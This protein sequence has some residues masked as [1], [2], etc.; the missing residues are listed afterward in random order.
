MVVAGDWWQDFFERDYDWLFA[1]AISPEETERAV[2]DLVALVGIEPGWR[3]LD[4]PGG[5]G[6]HAVPL[7]L[8]GCHVTV[9]DRSPTLLARARREAAG[10]PGLRVVDAD[11][12]RPL[13]LSPDHGLHGP[14]FDLVAN[15]FNSLGYFATVDEDHA[16]LDTLAGQV[17]AGGVLVVEVANPAA[18]RAVP[19]REVTRLHDATV[20]AH[21]QW[22]ARSRRLSI[23]Y[24]VEPDDGGPARTTGTAQRLWEADELATVLGD[25]GLVVDDVLGDLDGRALD[26]ETDWMVVL[27]RRP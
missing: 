21:R 15:L 20:R 25:V 5:A 26:D 22:D 11:L 19:A 1:D 6:R 14:P 9:V 23:H 13:D 3:V 4:A 2:N 17:G 7:L 8:L 10:R 12:R 18:A 24:R 27:A 16:M